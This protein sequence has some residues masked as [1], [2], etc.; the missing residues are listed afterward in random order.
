MDETEVTNAEYRQFVYWV[1][2]S[3]IRTQLAEMAIGIDDQEDPMW[4]YK[5]KNEKNSDETDSN[6]ENEYNFY[7]DSYGEINILDWDVDLIFNRW[8]ICLEKYN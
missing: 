2:D 5:Y 6:E 4:Q 7:S 1:R 8:N 3:I